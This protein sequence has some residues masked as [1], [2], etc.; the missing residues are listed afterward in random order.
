MAWYST[1]V[2]AVTNGS[3]T[4]TGTGTSWVGAVRAGDGFIG[5]N[6]QTLEI[7]TIVSA[8]ELTLRTAY[9]GATASDQGYA[10]IPT[11]NYVQDV[12]QSLTAIRDQ[13]QGQA[14]SILVGKMPDLIV[15][16]AD[17]DTGLVR[18]GSN[19]LAMRAGGTDQLAVSEGVATGAAVQ[20]SEDDTTAGR[21]ARADY[22]YS[23]GNLLGTVSQ[24]GGTPTGAVIERG[25]NA[26]GEY[27]R[28]ADGTQICTFVDT[29]I[30]VTNASGSIYQSAAVSWTFPATFST[31]TGLGVSG[32][33]G[34]SRRWLTPSTPSTT[35]VSYRVLAP[36][37]DAST[38]A[39]Q[40]LAIGRWF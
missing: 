8:T 12:A 34:V 33:G 28:F 7:S 30:E 31:T 19:A 22:A 23:P 20:A 39:P 26:N 29:A 13:L 21:L 11:A 16:E 35:A 40:L 25:S 32:S 5:P 17:Q 4:V 38:Y 2:V 24:S 6:G 3:T 9:Q 36:A 15:Y 10:I 14:D 1:G 18:T 27:V 37:S